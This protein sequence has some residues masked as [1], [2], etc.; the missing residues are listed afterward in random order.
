MQ[1]IPTVSAEP[2]VGDNI[3][4]GPFVPASPVLRQTLADAAYSTLLEAIVSGRLPRGAILTT[5]EIANRLQI[6][7]TPAQEALRRLAADGLVE[8][9]AGKRAKV[10]QFSRREI[11]EVY[12]MRLL[13]EGECAARAVQHSPPE[14][15]ESIRLRLEDLLQQETSPDWCLRAL[16]CDSWFHTQLASSSQ[17]KRLQE[18]VERY[19]LLVRS[20]CRIVG[21][22]KNLK[23][24]IHE[25]LDVVS[26][27]EQRD[28]GGARD[29]M[30]NH[31]RLRLNSVL[32]AVESAENI[33]SYSVDR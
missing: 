26:A 23:A 32:E 20:F 18:D 10:V 8:L 21:T 15:V 14:Q 27:L 9:S 7:R 31:I 28:P 5:V 11:R 6:S 4:V 29:A 19:R 33:E 2:D 22:V 25:H 3:P 12:E 17:H 13:L 1:Q 24:A 16:E 30:Q